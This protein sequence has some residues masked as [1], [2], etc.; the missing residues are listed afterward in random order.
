MADRWLLCARLADE[1]YTALER[2]REHRGQRNAAQ[3]TR[4]E[5]E[6]LAA[7]R[8]VWFGPMAVVRYP[9]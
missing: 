7:G 2:A 8:A 4:N 1:E 3:G 5:R 6:S 9:G